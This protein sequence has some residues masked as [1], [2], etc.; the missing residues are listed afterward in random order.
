[1]SLPAALPQIHIVWIIT[2]NI[3]II[4]SSRRHLS[5][6]HKRLVAVA[7]DHDCNLSAHHI[8]CRLQVKWRAMSQSICWFIMNKI[9][10]NSHTAPH[11]PRLPASPKKSLT[12]SLNSRINYA[13]WSICL[14]ILHTICT[15]LSIISTNEAAKTSANKWKFGIY[16]HHSY[17][18]S[19][20]YHK[21]THSRLSYPKQYKET[22]HA[23]TSLSTP[24][25]SQHHLAGIAVVSCLLF[26]HT[27]SLVIHITYG[28][29]AAHHM[30]LV[31]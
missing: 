5:F 3:H 10:A 6:A 8:A 20:S 22:W 21:F 27:T 14:S 26:I 19:L 31:I 7:I 9:W 24:P 25:S 23:T 29:F 1:M 28:H 11:S 17:I 18:L 16:S 12:P 30:R 15:L 13:I 2:K 4:A